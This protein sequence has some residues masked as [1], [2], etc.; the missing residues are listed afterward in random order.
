MNY[1]Y[2]FITKTHIY[3]LR[4]I[5]SNPEMAHIVVKRPLASISRILNRVKHP[6]I[7]TL[8]Y[9]SIES[10]SSDETDMDR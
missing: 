9:C 5:E 3:A 7:I 8:K 10:E 6:N 4:E 2:L 1:S